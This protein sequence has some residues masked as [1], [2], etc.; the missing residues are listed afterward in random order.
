MVSPR[1]VASS[2]E[3]IDLAGSALG[4]SIVVTNEIHYAKKQSFGV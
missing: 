3:S 1:P 4:I 2:S